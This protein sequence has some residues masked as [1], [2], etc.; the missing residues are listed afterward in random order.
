MKAKVLLL[1]IFCGLLLGCRSKHKITTTY[2]ENTK[3]TEKVKVDSSVLQT[4]QSIQSESTGATLR[5]ENNKISG[6][7]LIKGKSDTSNPFVFHNVVGSDTIQS[8][9]IMGNAEYTISNHYT[10]AGSQKS[11][12]KKSET[13]YAIQDITQTT[14]SKETTKEVTSKV[15]EETKKIKLNGFDIA[16]WI[17]ITIL[18]ITL[19]LIF[20]TYKYFKK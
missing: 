11:E 16:A 12:I 19:I 5:E 14:A 6:D 20:F 4:L 9:S 3:A 8:I 10:K 1:I 17:F 18:G 7:L 2:K 13:V 15:S